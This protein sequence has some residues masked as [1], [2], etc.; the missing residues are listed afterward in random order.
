MI[1]T[2][3]PYSHV[4]FDHRVPSPHAA[5]FHGYRAT[6]Y[7][8]ALLCQQRNL[9]NLNYAGVIEGDFARQPINV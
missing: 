7:N 9:P 6:T 2:M 4:L 5:A 1:R 3:L 8:V